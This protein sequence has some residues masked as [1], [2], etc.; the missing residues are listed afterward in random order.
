MRA[1]I[2]YSSKDRAA[3]ESLVLALQERGIDCWWDQW[4]IDAGTDIVSAIN[5]GLDNADAGI[6]VFSNHSRE[7][8]WVDAEASYLTYARIQEGKPVIPVMVHGDAWVPPLLRPLARRTIDEADAIADALRNR[9]AGPPTARKP[10]HGR[11]EMVLISLR[12]QP[13]GLRVQ[14]RFGNQEYAASL[15]PSM[16]KALQDAHAAFLR[17]FRSGARSPQAAERMALE[18]NLGELGRALRELCL[19]D[20]AGEALADLVRGCQVGTTVEICVEANDRDLLALPFE[21]IRLPDDSLL[22]TLPPVAIMRR[23]EGVRAGSMER[24]AGPLKILVAVGAPDEKHASAAVLDLERELQNILDAVAPAQRLENVEVRILEVGHPENI[25]DA[26]RADAYHVLHI[27]CHGLP[28]ALELEDEDGRAVRTT[29]RDLL[30]PIS[31]TGRPLPMVFLNS[32]HGGV[33]DGQAA[34]FAEDLLRAGIPC[35][36]A[37]QSSVTDRYATQ[38]ALKFYRSLA[39]GETLLPSRALADARGELERERL[40]EG[41]REGPKFQT[42]PEYASASLFVAD[43]ERPLADFGRDKEPLKT[44]VVRDMAGPVPQLRLGDARSFESCS[45]LCATRSANSLEWC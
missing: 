36:L 37:M 8:R 26:I 28:G 12:R 27:S 29:A 45:E 40:A 35:V 22:A 39:K 43:E 24:L 10:E 18:R 6:I 3:V 21:A 44:R 34:S 32:C 2:S 41:Q 25:A 17:G 16:S 19:P 42:P 4:H 9:T 13:E 31:R 15:L 33:H 1:F 14:V 23:P 7:S 38:L 5:Q 11:V 30:E 20:G